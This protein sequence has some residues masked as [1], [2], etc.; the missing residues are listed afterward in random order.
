MCWFKKKYRGH[1]IIWQMKHAP[2]EEDQPIM[3]KEQEI[4]VVDLMNNLLKSHHDKVK[5]IIKESVKND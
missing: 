2:K 5:E 4:M 1:G 3:T